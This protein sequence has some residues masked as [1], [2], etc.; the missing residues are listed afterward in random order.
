VKPPLRNVTTL[1]FDPVGSGLLE[2]DDDELLFDEALKLFDEEELELLLDDEEALLDDELAEEVDEEELLLEVE[3]D[4]SLLDSG[5]I[6]L[7]E[8][9]IKTPLDSDGSFE[10]PVELAL[11]VLQPANV[12]AIKIVNNLNGFIEMHL[13]CIEYRYIIMYGNWQ[14]KTKSQSNIFDI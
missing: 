7:T 1:C 8:L 4:S 5:S 14:S 10:T 11:V 13:F 12:M 6:E 3:L 9:G 2:E